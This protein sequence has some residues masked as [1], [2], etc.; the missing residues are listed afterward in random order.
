LGYGQ[1]LSQ[2]KYLTFWLK[3]SVKTKVEISDD[4]NKSAS[5]VDSTCDDWKLIKICLSDF[6]DVDLNNVTWQFM[7]TKVGSDNNEVKV[8]DIRYTYC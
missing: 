2:F 8:A 7:I 4:C 1:D 6:C 3:S 5:Y